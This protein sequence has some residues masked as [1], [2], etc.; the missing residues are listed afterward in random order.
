M[1]LHVWTNIEYYFRKSNNTVAELKNLIDDL[2]WFL[3]VA[4]ERLHELEYRWKEIAQKH[5]RGQKKIKDER[6]NEYSNMTQ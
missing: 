6:Q 1:A 4:E 2:K 3:D 5:H